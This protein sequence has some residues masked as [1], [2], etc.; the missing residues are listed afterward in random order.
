MYFANL[1]GEDGVRSFDRG[2]SKCIPFVNEH[3][4]TTAGFVA[5]KDGKLVVSTDGENLFLKGIKNEKDDAVLN[6]TSHKA[7]KGKTKHLTFKEIKDTDENP[8]IIVLCKEISLYDS[9]P[10]GLKY[11]YIGEDYMLACLIYG[12]CD[13]DGITMQRCNVTDT[14]GKQKATFTGKHLSLFSRCIDPETEY[15]YMKDVV[16]HVELSYKGEEGCSRYST[17]TSMVNKF[18][19]RGLKEAQEQRARDLIRKQQVQ[20]L[21][22]SAEQERVS[23]IDKKRQDI[24]QEEASKGAAMFLKAVQELRH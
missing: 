13:F 21:K 15:C 8:L 12:A 24:E 18:D 1:L 7:H 9:I 16:N 23:I 10:T 3:E 19:E 11:I 4:N 14:N 5:L 20:D 22:D 17:V 6:F 2:S